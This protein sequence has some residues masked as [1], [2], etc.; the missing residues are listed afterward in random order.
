MVVVLQANKAELARYGVT[1]AD[2]CRSKRDVVAAL[3][4]SKGGA[5]LGAISWD[6]GR[7]ACGNSF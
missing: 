4:A 5:A 6:I 2:S 3:L 7:C 1:D